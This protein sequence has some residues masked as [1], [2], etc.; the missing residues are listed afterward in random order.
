MF[1]IITSYNEHVFEDNEQNLTI[2]T[3]TVPI[4]IYAQQSWIKKDLFWPAVIV[5]GLNSAIIF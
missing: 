3:A 1:H 5:P 2:R 4:R